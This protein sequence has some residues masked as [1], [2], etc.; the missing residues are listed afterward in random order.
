VW[1]FAARDA[2][3]AFQVH[4]AMVNRFAGQAWTAKV[5]QSML[6][7]AH[8]FDRGI[9]VDA[10][11]ADKPNLKES[12]PIIVGRMVDWASSEQAELHDLVDSSL[13]AVQARG[14]LPVDDTMVLVKSLYP[15]A[16]RQLELPFRSCKLIHLLAPCGPQGAELALTLFADQPSRSFVQQ[17]YV[18]YADSDALQTLAQIC[19][20]GQHPQRMVAARMLEHRMSIQGIDQPAFIA[21]ALE[22]FHAEKV[23]EC[24]GAI[25]D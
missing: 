15:V 8:V 21:P 25:P 18:H 2:E 17:I 1:R 9:A 12:A 6:D 20:N 24:T 11:L 13:T 23:S 3:A 19:R 14:P 4:C 16:S 22:A 7:G 10:L 5:Y